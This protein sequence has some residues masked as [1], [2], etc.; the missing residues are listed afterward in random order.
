MRFL[1]PRGARKVSG[2]GADCIL[3]G[4][5]LTSARHCLIMMIRFPR[6]LV[7][8]SIATNEI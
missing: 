2:D 8:A 1:P 4:T 5:L 6:F 7:R 3:C